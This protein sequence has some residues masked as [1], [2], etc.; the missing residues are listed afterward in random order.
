MSKDIVLVGGGNS[1]RE[2]LPLLWDKLKESKAEIWSI[3]FAFMCMPFLPS[4]EIWVDISFFRNNMETL[5]KL[6]AQSVKCCC[7]KHMSYANISEITTYE[8][9]RDPKEMDRKIY[10]GR[11][12]LGGFFA[13]HLAIKE[14]S[15]NIYLLGFDFG[16]NSSKTHF[17][18]DVIEVKSTGVGKPEL[19][20]NGTNIKDEVSDW[21]YF[22]SPD[23]KTKI[24]NV[25]PESSITCFEKINYERFYSKLNENRD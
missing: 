5:Q 19:Y 16:S 10:I 2:Q 21:Q 15:E 18:Q 6:Q 12:G 22:T 3:N 17:Y 24:Y 11:M 23:I 25:S 7:K 9:T 8:A 20:R 4:R 13:L 14:N 1:I